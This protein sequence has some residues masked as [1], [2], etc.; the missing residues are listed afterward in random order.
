[1]SNLTTVAVAI[2]IGAILRSQSANAANTENDYSGSGTGNITTTTNWSLGHVP[3]A[4]EDAVFNSTSAAGI[5][6]YGGGAT[7]GSP[8]TVGS[9]DVTAATG[10]YSI[11]NDTTG[12][13]NAILKLGGAGDLGNGVSGAAAD[14]L[15]A[16]TGSTLQLL[17]VN[18]SSGTGVLNV[19]LGQSGNFNAAGTINVS[20]IISDGGSNFAITKTGAGTLQLSGANTYGGGLTLLAGTFQLNSAAA[21]GSGTF[22]I[23][24]G[25]ITNTS[26]ADIT[27]SNN[28]AQIWGGDFTV[29]VG[30]GTKSLNLGT[31]AV[32][33]TGNRQVN[34]SGVTSTLT[35]GGSIGGSGFSLTRGGGGAGTLILAANNTYSGGTII[36]S[37]KLTANHDGALGTGNVSLTGSTVTLTLQNGATNNYIN[38]SASLSVITGS[39]V[40]L[41][42]SGTPDT[43]S[44][45]I[46][47]GVSQA[48]GTYGAGNFSELTGTGMITV[49]GIPEPATWMLMGV[50]LLIGAQR[51]RR[52][53]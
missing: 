35:V 24:G 46:V 9:L 42:F 22:T 48:A 34:V 37:G 38:D 8:V 11:R 29:A 28:N 50:G 33:L 53:N 5:K 32:T 21:P 12:A 17:G 52:K 49:I 30:S 44:Q 23:N 27:L 19:V 16:A 51:L 26:V 1:M 41:N 4:S 18:G 25:T 10:T 45:F 20:S 14:L 47:N 2:F 36:S 3:T 43:V 7:V 40:N 6:N 13:T 15:F 31:G 39:T